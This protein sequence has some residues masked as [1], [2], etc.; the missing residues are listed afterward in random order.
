MNSEVFQEVIHV[1]YTYGMRYVVCGLAASLVIVLWGSRRAR[2][3]LR[4]AALAVAVIGLWAGLFAGVDQGYRAWQSIPNPPEEA[5][6]DTGGPFTVL[7]LGWV[8][9]AFLLSSVHLLLRMFW[10][11]TSLTPER[12]GI[13]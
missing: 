1:L 13:I 9:C 8:P 7:F 10:C 12:E 2:P 11:R 6:S 3:G 5:F 4:I